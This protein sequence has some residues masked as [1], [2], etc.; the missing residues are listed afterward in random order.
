MRDFKTKTA[1]G[2]KVTVVEVPDTLDLHCS[3]DFRE[4][5][6]ELVQKEHCR[7]VMDLS[8]TRYVDSSGLS[9]FVS[10]IAAAR[11]KRGDIRFAAPSKFILDLF[12]ITH[13]NQ[14][15]KI[16]DDVDSAVE[17]FEDGQ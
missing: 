15:L 9:A 2:G 7:I 3:E 14:I 11:S 6:E 16:F 8:K 1:L 13:L 4:L 10:R 17:S 5:V 12:Q